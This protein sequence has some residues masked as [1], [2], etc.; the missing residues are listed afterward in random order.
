MKNK[1]RISDQFKYLIIPSFVLFCLLVVLVFL[2]YQKEFTFFQNIYNNEVIQRKSLIVGRFHDAVEISES[3]GAFFAS[4][5]EVTK[6]EFEL[7]GSKLI[8]Q[9]ATEDYSIPLMIEWADDQNIIRYVYPSNAEN[10]KFIGLNLNHYKNRIESTL[11]A[12]RTRSSIVTEPIILIEGY[13]GALIFSPVFKNGRYLG[14]TIVVIRLK[15]ILAPMSGI[16]Q[17]YS[18]DEYF[19]TNDFIIPFDNDVI[20]TT[21][22]ERVIN[23]QGDLVKDVFSQ[24]YLVPK[25]G[26]VSEYITFANKNVKLVIFPTFRSEVNIRTT[27]YAIISLLFLLIIITFL[28]L[29]QKRRSLLL[30]EIAKTEALIFGIG[31]GLVA[32]D[33]NGIITLVNEKAEKLCGYISSESIGKSYYDIWKL[34]D[35]KGV[36]VP[37]NLRPFH[38]A[39]T[40][41]KVTTVTIASHLYILKKDGTRFPLESTITPIIVKN[42]V[43][44]AIAV[45]R[46]IT[47]EDEIDRMK[48]EFL[49]L[50]THQLLTPST[51]IKWMTDLMLKG[52]MG[53]LK[54]KQKECVNDI[55]NSNESM[56]KLIN[57]LLNISRIESGRIIIDPKPTLLNDLVKETARELKNKINI[58]KQ[59]LKFDLEKNLP[60]INVDQ[61]LI[62]E[63]YK[64]ILTNAIKYTP[65]NGKII[66]SITSD[67]ENII[68]KISDNGYGIPE[69]EQVKVFEKFYRGENIK[70]KK[71]G[72][73]LGLY[74]V[75]QIIEV[76]GGKVGFESK[77]GKGTSFWFSLPLSGSKPK[78]GEVT[79]T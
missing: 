11:E 72:S 22:G 52:K 64:N 78:A 69:N 60:K 77:V 70:T 1:K 28:W 2:L 16:Y 27:V 73:G 48:T 3:T 30:N 33:K 20:Y 61:N 71:E 56:I 7:F 15:N 9:N 23:P 21:S 29:L 74:L 41:N 42:K 79:I 36:E 13:P 8:K 47:K 6:E 24:K 38:I 53:L 4:S 45:F 75:K 62:S 32:C 18:N 37:K 34:V 40:E 19:Q 54:K 44:G 51:A 55:Y 25:N 31:D 59:S 26:T 10:D 57:S 5:Q 66:V 63:V 50:A 65:E 43:E 46:D 67:K 12:Q 17:D 76:S 49:S 68:S 39:L 58:K 35:K 14:E